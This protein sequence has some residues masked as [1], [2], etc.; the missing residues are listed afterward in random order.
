[1]YRLFYKHC[2]SGTCF[3]QIPEK[4]TD[5][6]YDVSPRQPDLASGEIAL[7]S[8]QEARGTIRSWS[9]TTQKRV[10]I[11]LSETGKHAQ[12]YQALCEMAKSC[13]L[14]EALQSN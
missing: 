1:M 8:D 12:K 14:D 4:A 7:R 9:I 5:F 3:L 13:D 10:E 6:E 11:D 2:L